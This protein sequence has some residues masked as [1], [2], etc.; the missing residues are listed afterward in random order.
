MTASVSMTGKE[1]S[2]LIQGSTKFPSIGLFGGSE[3]VNLRVAKGYAVCTTLGVVLSRSSLPVQGELPLIAV[4]E[5]LITPFANQHTEATKVTIDVNDTNI[6]IR[7]RGRKI[8]AAYKEGT[9][10]PFPKITAEGIEITPSLA[11]RVGYLSNVAFSDLSRPDLCCV[12]ILPDGRAMACNSRAIVVL[13]CHAGHKQKI[14]M[15]LPLAKALVKGNTIFPGVK[16]TAIKNGCAKYCMPSPSRALAEFP[17]EAIDSYAKIESSMVAV[18]K[19]SQMA[20]AVTEADACMGALSRLEMVLKLSL[21]NG[22]AAMTTENGSARYQTKMQSLKMVETEHDL[23]LPMEEMLR[24]SPFLEKEESVTVLLGNKNR[25]A[26]LKFK[27]G[28]A[29][30]PK[31]EKK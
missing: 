13:N 14:A 2:A 20:R 17:I 26:F 10:Q 11:E 7:A 23:N 4:D 27:N 28:W 24:I 12:M 31:W 16:E 30:F 9:D 3:M 1:F 29:M 15:P 8:E 5:R 22:K 19:G 25:E 18:F 21:A 6:I